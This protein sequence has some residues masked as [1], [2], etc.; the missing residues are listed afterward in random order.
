[1]T[2]IE[3]TSDVQE[4]ILDHISGKLGYRAACD[5][6]KVTKI[7]FAFVFMNTIKD[8]IRQGKVKIDV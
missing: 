7:S 3:I 5:K 1:M 8:L 2:K 4:V 6:L